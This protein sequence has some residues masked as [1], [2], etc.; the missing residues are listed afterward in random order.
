M[1]IPIESYNNKIKAQFAKN[2]NNKKNSY[3]FT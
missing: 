3:I 2:V 1:R